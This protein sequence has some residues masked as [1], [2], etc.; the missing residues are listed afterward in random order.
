[1]PTY[2]RVQAERDA[3]MAKLREEE[4]GKPI[5]EDGEVIID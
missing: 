5:N 2:R 4:E 1:M 3:Q